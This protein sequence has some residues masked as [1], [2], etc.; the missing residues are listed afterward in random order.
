MMVSSTNLSSPL[1]QFPIVLNLLLISAEETSNN[2]Y[3]TTKNAAMTLRL[4]GVS[5][6]YSTTAAKMPPIR[7][8]N[9]YFKIHQIRPFAWDYITAIAAPGPSSETQDTVDTIAD[10]PV[11]KECPV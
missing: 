4:E 9:Y 6:V 8:P 2:D 11:S 3:T 7:V 10:G 5:K 1:I